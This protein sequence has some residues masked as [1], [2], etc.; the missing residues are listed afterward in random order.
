MDKLVSTVALKF[1]LRRYRW[2]QA[3]RVVSMFEAGGG[4]QRVE[5]AAGA[6]QSDPSSP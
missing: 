3:N 6:Q 5:A 4:G 2:E 1:K